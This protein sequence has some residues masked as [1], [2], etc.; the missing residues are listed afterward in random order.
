MHINMKYYIVT[1]GAIFIALG[2]GMLVGFNLNYD[3]ELS[4]QQASIIA[5]LDK[6]FEGLK[7]KNDNLEKKL[8]KT[9]ENYDKSIEFIEENIDK[10]IVDEL[11]DK[12]IGVISTNENNEYSKEIEETIVKANGNV[13]FDIVLKDNIYNEKKIEEASTKIG[14]EIKNTQEVIDYIIESL[15]LEGVNEKLKNL[16]ELEMIKINYISDNYLDYDSVVLATGSQDKDE[17]IK[18]EKIDKVVGSKLKAENKKIVAVQ[19]SE[20]NSSYVDLYSKDKI[21]T[22][23]NIDQGTGKLSLVMILKE[24]NISGKYGVLEDTD[25][26][27]PY[28]K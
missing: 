5:D 18:F 11:V 2:I 12:N 3:Q 17:N 23:D 15:K 22:I 28:K 14:L 13:A 25:S 19:R 7:L 26:I 6:R 16:E 8:S 4:E 24:G 10:L 21:T 20:H 1:I 9:S 27:L